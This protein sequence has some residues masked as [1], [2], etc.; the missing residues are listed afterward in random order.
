MC[1][2]GLPGR[3]AGHRALTLAGAASGPTDGGAAATAAATG[4]PGSA[5]IPATPSA[6]P[7]G[8]P[9]ATSAAVASGAPIGP[10]TRPTH[11]RTGPGEQGGPWVVTAT[12]TVC[13]PACGWHLL[14]A[15][16]AVPVGC[17]VECAG[18]PAVS[19]V[20]PGWLVPPG[21]QPGD[22]C[23][24]GELW[25]DRQPGASLRTGQA[26]QPWDLWRG[27]E[28]PEGGP[29]PGASSTECAATTGDVRLG[30]RINGG[31]RD[32]T[33]STAADRVAA[34]GCVRTP[35]RGPGPG[36]R[37]V[38]LRGQLTHGGEEDGGQDGAGIR[39]YGR[40]DNPVFSATRSGG[41]H[42]Q[43]WTAAAAAGCVCPRSLSPWRLDR[44]QGEGIP[45]DGT[46]GPGRPVTQPWPG[47]V[48]PAGPDGSGRSGPR[49]RRGPV[50]DG[51]G[52]GVARTGHR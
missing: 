38:H 34:G 15:A 16:W 4:R 45:A 30:R 28:L 32:S 10:C 5:N 29:G 40:W 18:P 50:C 41:L 21:E 26:G 11:P 6:L 9:S 17:V 51:H 7:I 43:R 20:S 14:V 42:R 44:R 31:F 46:E 25:P 19:P 35:L 1:G 33:T 2:A 23:A 3:S 47:L 49:Q 12:G 48:P 24:V 37:P 27:A 36:L 22:R 13:P 39:R 8:A 52:P